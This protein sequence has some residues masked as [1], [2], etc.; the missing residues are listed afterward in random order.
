LIVVERRFR[1]DDYWR[2]FLG[3]RLFFEF[4]FLHERSAKTKQENKYGGRDHPAIFH[5][6]YSAFPLRKN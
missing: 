3:G 2:K 1:G 4:G 5:G 6:V